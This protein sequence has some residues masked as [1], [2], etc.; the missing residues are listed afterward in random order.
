MRSNAGLAFAILSSRLA[1]YNLPIGWQ[2]FWDDP[3]RG[4]CA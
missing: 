1:V 4:E 3:F 2:I